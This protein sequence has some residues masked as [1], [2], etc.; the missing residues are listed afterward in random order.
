M[1]TKISKFLKSKD[2]LGPFLVFF[3]TRIVLSILSFLCLTSLTINLQYR[4]YSA[5]PL[6]TSANKFLEGF[7]RWDASWYI[8]IVQ[9]GYF[10]AKGGMSSIAFFPFYPLLIRSL[11]VFISD[12]Y[13][14]GIL[15]SNLCFLGALI[16]L[17]K[18]V[19]IK[20]DER[21]A[22]KTIVLVACFPFSFFFSSIYSES[23]FLLLVVLT[24][25][26]LEKR[27]WLWAAL[28]VSLASIT[29]LQGIFLIPILVFWP[30]TKIKNGEKDKLLLILA[31]LLISSLGLVFFVSYNQIKFGNGLAFLAAHLQGWGRNF[32]LV[33]PEHLRA[34]NL[35]FGLKKID[36]GIFDLLRITNFILS[37]I[38]I[39]FLP[40]VYKSLGIFYTLFSF[41]GIVI[42]FA[43]SLWS[44]ERFLMVV[45]PVFIVL[46][47]LKERYFLPLL[48]V[49]C[50]FLG[51][52]ASLFFLGYPVQ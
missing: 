20:I 2:F 24:F 7:I 3:L 27:K 5:F 38:W 40:A 28:A 25:F 34:I 26:L 48:I 44:M 31:S 41:L 22:F 29:R 15:I 52:W 6:Y 8:D 13:L 51:L 45:F 50:T 4:F 39:L 36:F 42:P 49:F 17:Y 14:A 30:F 32:N 43:N 1:L 23:L 46:A 21:T 37:L 18:L 11:Q 19:K 10:F 12:P 47:K 9:K 35:L 33:F 16:L